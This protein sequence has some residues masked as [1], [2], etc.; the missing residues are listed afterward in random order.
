MAD[1]LTATE[2]GH[3]RA[4]LGTSMLGLIA[5]VWSVVPS[6]A[7]LSFRLSLNWFDWLVR[8]RMS[9]LGLNVPMAG[10]VRSSLS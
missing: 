8:R 1:K 3:S 4:T 5:A 9:Q 7:R 10:A 2:D 6:T